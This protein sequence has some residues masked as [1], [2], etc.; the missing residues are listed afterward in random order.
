MWAAETD[1]GS[2][3]L[4]GPTVDIDLPGGYFLSGVGLFGEFKD[5]WDGT[6]NVQDGEIVYGRIFEYLDAGIGLRYV[7]GKY[8]EFSYAGYGPMLYVAM[9]NLFADGPLGWYGSS[10]LDYEVYDQEELPDGS[11][12]TIEG[13][14]YLSWS[15]WMGTLGYRYET[16]FEEVNAG[17]R[18]VAASVSYKF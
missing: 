6:Y 9:G 11:I 18:G 8:E 10:T 2:G 14:L 16:S 13:G 17:M 12:V 15:G 7:S 5:D 3:I 1:W 4:F